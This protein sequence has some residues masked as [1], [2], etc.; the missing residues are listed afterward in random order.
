MDSLK[1]N[2]LWIALMVENKLI[3]KEIQLQRVDICQ[4]ELI[5]V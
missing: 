5:K 2:N 1:Q 3:S 4:E